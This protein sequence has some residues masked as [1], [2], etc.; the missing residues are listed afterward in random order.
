MRVLPK[1]PAEAVDRLWSRQGRR[2]LRYLKEVRGLKEG[3][4]AAARL[5]F[6]PGDPHAW[7]EVDGLR[8][9]CGITIPWYGDGVIWG[10]KVRR[11]AGEQRYQQVSRRQSARL[12][13]SGG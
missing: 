13:V 5:G 10:I 3:I 2:A 4:I 12:S 6:I 1:A 7:Q 8:V 11:A 9:P